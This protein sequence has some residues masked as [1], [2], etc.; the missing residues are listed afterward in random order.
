MTRDPINNGAVYEKYKFTQT[1]N[2]VT[3]IVTYPSPI[4]GKDVKCKITNDELFLQIKGETFINGKLSKLVKKNDCCWT[5]EDKTTIVI[6]LVKQKTMDW[7]S[8]VIIGDEEIDTKKIKA[9]TVGDVNELDS[10][11]KELVQKMMFDQ[12]QKD[13]GLPTSDEIDKMKAFEK[14]KTQ[15]PE[16]D[17]SNAKMMN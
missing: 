8:C 7:W 11:T 14:F 16:M 4:K 6:D 15:H 17:F 12:H 1:L 13:L 10:D 2:E 9:E 3:V 5:I